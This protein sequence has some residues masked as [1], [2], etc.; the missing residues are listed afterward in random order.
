MKLRIK[1]AAVISA[2]LMC[3]AFVPALSGCSGETAFTLAETESGE[4]YY[5]ASATGFTNGLKGELII[6]AYY[7]EEGT[8]SY[9]PVKEIADSGFSGTAITKVTIPATVEK[10]GTAA[11]AYT[12]DLRE[13]V[14]EDGSEI[15]EIPHGCFGYSSVNKITLPQGVKTVRELAFSDCAGLREIILPEGVET[16]CA[17]TFQN[18]SSLES[19]TFPS[20][21]VTVGAL[22][23]YSCTALK[24]ITL[25]DGMH[26]TERVGEDGQTTVSPAIGC[27]AF[28][29][30]SALTVARI[31]EG[32]TSMEEGVFG[33]CTSLKSVY[34]PRTLKTIKGPRYD[35]NGDFF[36][37][38]AFHHDGAL[39]TIYFAGTK[40]EWEKIEIASEPLTVSG[41]IFDNSAILSKTPIFGAQ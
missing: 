40:E 33:A 12:S 6:P 22:A 23:F 28:H 35:G 21:L 2:A 17:Q 25:P 13:V 1:I 24:E 26:E 8:D 20:T 32:V 37:G 38:H 19:V 29:T 3:A 10:I 36:C 27:A 11:F 30:C 41:E 15:S 16:I 39:E 4:K 18:C 14:F 7:G 9:A 5:I 31:G 34:F